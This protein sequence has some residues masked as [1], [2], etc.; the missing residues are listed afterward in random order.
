MRRSLLPHL[1][2]LNLH[3]RGRANFNRYY[4]PSNSHRVVNLLSGIIFA[5]V[6]FP[7]LT[8]TPVRRPDWPEPEDGQR[9]WASTGSNS[10]A[11]P[12]TAAGITL[13]AG[14]NAAYQVLDDLGLALDIDTDM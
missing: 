9:L 8:R 2:Q 4:R 14:Y 5:D 3:V 13:I 12:A 10:V 7:I 11:P 6:T 1:N